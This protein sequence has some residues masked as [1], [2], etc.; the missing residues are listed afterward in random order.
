MPRCPNEENASGGRSD[1]SV[2][3]WT[4]HGKSEPILRIDSERGDEGLGYVAGRA[5]RTR[6]IL[7]LRPHEASSRPRPSVSSSPRSA[8]P[9]PDPLEVQLVHVLRRDLSRDSAPIGVGHHGTVNA[10]RFFMHVRDIST[11]RSTYVYAHGSPVRSNAQTLPSKHP[12]ARGVLARLGMAGSRTLRTT[13]TGFGRGVTGLVGMRGDS[14]RAAHQSG[15]AIE[16][17]FWG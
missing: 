1:G 11:N 2:R 14:S 15:A 17:S 7:V 12:A 3:A 10:L 9:T 13:G 4:H 16:A 8:R 6:I 5:Q